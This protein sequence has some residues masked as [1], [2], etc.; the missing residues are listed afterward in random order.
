MRDRTPSDVAAKALEEADFWLL[1]RKNDLKWEKEE[2]EAVTVR[3]KSWSV[4]PSGWLKGNIGVHWNKTKA[5]CGAAWVVRDETG[6]VLMHSRRAIFNVRSLDEAK[7]QTLLWALESF[8]SHHLNRI[9]IALEDT[10]L[11]QVVT[12]PKR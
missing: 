8:G 1:A 10:T 12:R 7:F 9:I 6:K 4:P 3:M 5:K 2:I 11:P